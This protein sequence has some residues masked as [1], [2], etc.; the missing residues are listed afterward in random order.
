MT[1]ASDPSTGVAS[2]MSR[3]LPCGMPSMMSMRATSPSSRSAR[4]CASVAPTFPAPTTVTFLFMF[5]S[6]RSS[7]ASA[8]NPLKIFDDG[9]GEFR[10]L[11]HLGPLHLALEVV[12]HAL[13]PDRSL[14]RRL[15][16]VRGLLPAQIAEHHAARED[17]GAR[18]D[19]VEVGIF[20]RGAVGGL[21]DGVAGLV[22][23][24]PA[25]RD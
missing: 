24:V 18:V 23:D 14:E 15:D 1:R 13:L 2:M 8:L 9:G 25:R 16:A 11:Q 19:L 6:L 21:E 20:R 22:V 10:G 3:P 7:A 17:D 12:R 4:R 5:L